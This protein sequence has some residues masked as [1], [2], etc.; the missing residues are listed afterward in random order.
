MVVNGG[1]ASTGQIDNAAA[2]NRRRIMNPPGKKQSG[3]ASV[4]TPSGSGT[5]LPISV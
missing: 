1:P 2:M 4:R 5:F 3:L